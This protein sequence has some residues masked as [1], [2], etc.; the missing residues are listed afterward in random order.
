MATLIHFE[1][2]NGAHLATRSRGGVGGV[3]MHHGTF[4]YCDGLASDGDH[5]WVPTGGVF[6]EQLIREERDDHSD[7]TRYVP[8]AIGS[9]G[10]LHLAR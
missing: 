7:D 1:C 8:H 4:G 10:P 6:L 5:R 2:R 9:A 3:V